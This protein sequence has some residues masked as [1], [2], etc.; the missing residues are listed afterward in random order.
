MTDEG[1][2]QIPTAAGLSQVAADGDLEAQARLAEIYV[3]S[4]RTAEA[5]PLLQA[6]AAAGHVFSAAQLG[7]W[8]II[9]HLVEQDV[10]KGFG[11]VERAGRGGDE[12][13]QTFLATLCAAGTGTKANPAKAIGWLVR[14][15]KQGHARALRQLG[16]LVPTAAKSSASRR[17]LLGLAA[18]RGDD[19]AQY[20]LGKLLYLSGD[21]DER[22]QAISWCSLAARAGNP[23]AS[24]FLAVNDLEPSNQLPAQI[25]TAPV[26]WSRLKKSLKLPD[27]ATGIAETVLREQPR[28]S[29]FKGFLDDDLC[30]YVMAAA[31]PYLKPA[32][33][34]DSHRGMDVLDPSRSNSMMG[35]FPIE[36]DVIIN[37]IYRRIA[38]RVG[39]PVEHGE[40]LGVLHYLPGQRYA[41]HYDFFDPDYP[42]HAA[43]IAAGGQRFK[44][45]LVYLNEEYEA[46][47]TLFG[48]LD[49][50]FK[51]GRGD[52]LLFNNVTPDGGV[53]RQTLH[54][55]LTPTS[56]QKWII[57]LWIRDQAQR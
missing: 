14:A 24:R 9:G 10:G 27:R 54:A 44:T 22:R 13:S 4:G 46:G 11:L 18:E 56:G 30:D 1:S 17:L 7:A 48:K 25:V 34:N 49:W 57:S 32:T 8:Y 36:N 23:A 2:E 45:V 55:G 38:D 40:V 29:T 16:C 12:I 19:I 20:F 42:V 6:A 5:L 47:E 37:S 26:I 31:A 53:D 3:D 52:A 33:V 21:P 51:G 35:F 15:A 50:K 43:E 28:I 39:F 41:P